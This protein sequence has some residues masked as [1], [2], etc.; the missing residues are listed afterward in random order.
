MSA[1]DLLGGLVPSF[2]S[3]LFGLG[4]NLMSNLSNERIN[5]KQLQFSNEINAQNLAL[6]RE[7]LNAQKQQQQWAN[8]QYVES[9]DYDRA[10]QQ[11]I[12]NREDTSISRAVED[13]RNAGFSPLAALGMSAGSGSVVSSSSAP[14]SMVSNNQASA[15]IPNLRSNDYGSLAQSGSQ[16]AQLLATSFEN[17]KA[18]DNQV[19]LTQMQLAEQANEAGLGRLHEKM[20][21]SLE[22]DFLQNQSNVEHYRQLMYKLSDQNFQVKLQEIISADNKALE[23][24]RQSWQ[25]S[26]N[27]LNRASSYSMQSSEQIWQSRENEKN[28]SSDKSRANY[29]NQ[30]IKALSDG[31]SKMSKWLRDNSDLLIPVLQYVDSLLAQ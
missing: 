12:F 24:Q 8:E 6:S 4:S 27:E 17:R 18:Q 10:L 11:T 2:V 20:M 21:K 29:L 19:F 3:G 23:S 22:H 7:A 16:I 13:A 25:S 30:I 31:D 1:L 28:R 9:R 15:S 5:D 14:G 26:E